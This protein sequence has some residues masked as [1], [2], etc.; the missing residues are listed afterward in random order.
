LLN[1]FHEIFTILYE[2]KSN[3]E[4]A[5]LKD[6]LRDHDDIHTNLKD[7][8]TEKDIRQ[9]NEAKNNAENKVKEATED[10]DP[11]LDVTAKTYEKILRENNS[12][13]NRIRKF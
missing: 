8:I 9:L 1:K 2:K 12:H 3:D 6:N 11:Q 4:K 5:K 7:V 10:L 13:A